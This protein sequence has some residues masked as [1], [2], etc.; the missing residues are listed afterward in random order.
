MWDSI[1]PETIIIIII[2]VI[3]INVCEG[4]R[5]TRAVRG[6]GD[7]CVRVG[8][9]VCVVVEEGGGGGGVLTPQLMAPQ[10]HLP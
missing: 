8:V 5:G 9:H 6:A 7:A 4:K 3:N 10:N 2:V 1:K